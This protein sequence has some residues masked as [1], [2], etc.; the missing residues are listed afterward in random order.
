MEGFN[1]K[2]NGAGLP[3]HAAKRA[4]LSLPLMNFVATI[5]QASEAASKL[6]V[7]YYKPLQLALGTFLRRVLGGAGVQVRTTDALKGH[8]ADCVILLLTPRDV[9]DQKPCA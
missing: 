2:D 5:L 1:W 8:T 9:G 4:I 6:V 7:V 3:K